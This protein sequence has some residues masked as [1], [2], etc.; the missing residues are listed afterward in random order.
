MFT[1]NTPLFYAVDFDHLI[2]HG[3][4]FTW[5]AWVEIGQYTYPGCHP[6]QGWEIQRNRDAFMEFVDMR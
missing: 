4:P 2:I 6:M 3:D 5:N 1:T